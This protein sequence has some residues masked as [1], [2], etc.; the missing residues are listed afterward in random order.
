[1]RDGSSM[2]GRFP[3]PLKA[4]DNSALF[5][6]RGRSIMLHEG[7]FTGDANIRKAIKWLEGALKKTSPPK[8][9]NCVECD[10]RWFHMNDCSIKAKSGDP[11]FGLKGNW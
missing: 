9:G 10:A 2:I 4:E 1:M 6:W 7:G 8:A 5:E 11:A 3:A